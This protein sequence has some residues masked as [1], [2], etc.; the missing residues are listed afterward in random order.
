MTRNSQE[1]KIQE[2]VPQFHVFLE[3]EVCNSLGG[4]IVLEVAQ[5][6][7]EGLDELSNCISEKTLKEN[8]CS[9]N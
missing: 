3:G 2:N 1:I 8:K 7:S 4:K 5:E 6:S 9:F